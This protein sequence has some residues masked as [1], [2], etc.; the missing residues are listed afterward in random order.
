MGRAVALHPLAVILA[1]ATGVVT[2]G[3][4]GG[5]VAVPLLAVVN[6]AVRYLANHPGGEPTADHELPGTQPTDEQEREEEPTTADASPDPGEDRADA[7][8]SR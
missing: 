2:A 4:V 3:I 5:V 6:T 1:I 7:G 8:A